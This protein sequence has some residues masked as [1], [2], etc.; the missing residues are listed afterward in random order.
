MHTCD[1]LGASR[2]ICSKYPNLALLVPWQ[3]EQKLGT[4]QKSNIIRYQKLP[5]L[6]GV[7]FSKPSFWVSMSV[8]GSVIGGVCLNVAHV[9]QSDFV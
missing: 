4:P 9:G 1:R 8:F 5:F 2:D 6:K 3:K 7:T